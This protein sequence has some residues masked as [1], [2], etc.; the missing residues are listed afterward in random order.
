MHNFSLFI[1]AVDDQG[2]YI[3]SVV[4][5]ERCNYLSFFFSQSMYLYMLKVYAYHFFVQAQLVLVGDIKSCV[6]SLCNVP[7]IYEYMQNS[8]I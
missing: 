6:H 7:N 2:M 8:F 5:V 4:V 1:S 3:K